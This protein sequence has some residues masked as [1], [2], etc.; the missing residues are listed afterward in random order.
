MGFTRLF[1]DINMQPDINLSEHKIF[2]TVE[3]NVTRYKPYV[4]SEAFTAV[5]MKNVVFW[6]INLVRT[7][8]ETQ[9]VFTTESSKLMLCKI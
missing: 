3:F 7:S 6:D 4:R 1:T 2:M 5:T 8:Q 9:Y